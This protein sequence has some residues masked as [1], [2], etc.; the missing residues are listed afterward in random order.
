MPM[1]TLAFLLLLATGAGCEPVTSPTI[2]E[3]IS[4]AFPGRPIAQQSGFGVLPKV[5][6]P[7][8]RPGTRGSVRQTAAFPDIPSNVTV[9]RVNDGHPDETLLRNSSNALG[10]PN[11]V[12]GDHPSGENIVLTWRDGKGL[13]WT[14]S[15]DGRRLEFTDESNPTKTLT[16]SA[17]PSAEEAVRVAEAFL[18]DHGVNISRYGQ[19]YVDPDWSAWWETQKERGRCMDAKTLTTVRALSASLSWELTTFP[20]L[21]ETDCLSPEFPSRMAVRFN[22]TQ[23]GQGIFTDTGSPAL[24]ATLFVDAARRAVVSGF[25]TLSADPFRSDYP[26][27]TR[28]EARERMVRGGQGGTPNGD[29]TITIVRFEWYPITNSATP[30]TRFL[31]PALVGEGRIEYGDGTSAPYR[32]VVPL[33]KQ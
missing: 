23:D 17:L 3:P 9:L 12:V 27:I 20:S 29:V 5:A 13:H 32:I 33:V 7:V 16:V 1:R 15:A 18:Q 25:F 30:P 6:T 4:Q 24:G 31:F 2:A 8:L 22:A 14:A 28:D 19:P 10:I 21:P 11:G 26:G